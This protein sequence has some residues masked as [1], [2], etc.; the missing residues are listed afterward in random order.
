MS[1]NTKYTDYMPETV[2][3][4]RQGERP[5]SLHPGH[6]DR[7]KRDTAR[8]RGEEKLL[9]KSGLSPHSM[10]GLADEVLKGE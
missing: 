10:A 4:L 9:R 7:L 2:S 1:K 6:G 3:K 5:S 8:L